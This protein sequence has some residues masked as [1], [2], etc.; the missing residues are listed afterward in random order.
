MTKSR[1]SYCRLCEEF[2]GKLNRLVPRYVDGILDD[3]FK[4]CCYCGEVYPLYDVKLEMEYEAKAQAVEN[5]FESGTKV[6]AIERKRKYKQEKHSRAIDNDN[7]ANIDDIP[8]FGHKEDK[9]LK[10]MLKD[11][12][13]IINYINDDVEPMDDSD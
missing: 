4:I 11:R 6:V 5:P 12:V 7:Y 2:T 3:K 13:G 9:E 10:G 1:K 8:K